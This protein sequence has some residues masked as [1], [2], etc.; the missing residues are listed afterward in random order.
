MH[1]EREMATLAECVD[2]LVEGDLGRLGDIMLQR[3]KALEKS[4]QDES[5]TI[6]AE[7]EGW[8][9]T[10]AIISARAEAFVAPPSMYDSNN[11]AIVSFFR[12]TTAESFNSFICF[13]SGRHLS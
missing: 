2:C 1:T 7:L 6:A 8:P 11:W 3:Y 5:W 4:V 10:C 13:T 9:D 12:R